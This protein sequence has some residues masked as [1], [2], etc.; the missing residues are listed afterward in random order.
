MSGQR[1]TRILR[2]PG[3]EERISP[4][5]VSA[6]ISD[7]AGVTP[8]EAGRAEGYARGVEEGQRDGSRQVAAVRKRLCDTLEE[9]NVLAVD[10]VRRHE[11]ELIR[12][13]LA[14]AARLLRRAVADGDPVVERTVREAVESFPPGASV[15]VK[16][17]PD[18]ADAMWMIAPDLKTPG[19]V[20][21]VPDASIEP[22]G[23]HLS[24]GDI[25]ADARIDAQL[26][27]LARDLGVAPPGESE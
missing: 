25:E 6:T 3:A 21:V 7:G 12:L 15:T 26:A 10:R 27:A 9:L 8:E 16:V 20:H 19:Q 14:I 11:K 18:D 22:G 4:L 1:E 17:H 23:A 2:A 24:D 5:V 13:A